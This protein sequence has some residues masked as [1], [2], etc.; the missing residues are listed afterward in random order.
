M[1]TIILINISVYLHAIASLDPFCLL[2]D[3]FIDLLS[4]DCSHGWDSH[5]QESYPSQ[6]ELLSKSFLLLDQRLCCYHPLQNCCSIL[7]SASSECPH[8]QFHLHHWFTCFGPN[9]D[10]Q[11]CS[12]LIAALDEALNASHDAECNLAYLWFKNNFKY[13]VP[14]FPSLSELSFLLL[15]VFV[16]QGC[17]SYFISLALNSFLFLLQWSLLNSLQ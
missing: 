6:N 11:V 14:D 8:C 10:S 4:D 17:V 12:V 13:F 3:L 1:A 2:F 5:C 7:L 9:W 15:A 16:V